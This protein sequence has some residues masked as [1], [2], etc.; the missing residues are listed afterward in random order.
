[1]TLPPALP[2][3]HT[4]RAGQRSSLQYTAAVAS[5]AGLVALANTGGSGFVT[6]P[7]TIRGAGHA[8]DTSAVASFMATSPTVGAKSSA[9]NSLSSEATMAARIAL[10][11]AAVV[12]GRAAKNQLTSDAGQASLRGGGVTPRGRSTSVS[13]QLGGVDFSGNATPWDTI[14]S[15]PLGVEDLQ[16]VHGVLL[17]CAFCLALFQAG[18]I[19][20]HQ[21]PSIPEVWTTTAIYLPWTYFCWRDT[22]KLEGH[23]QVTFYASCGWAIMSLAS[24]HSVAYQASAPDY[25]LAI[26]YFGNFINAIAGIYFYGYHWSRM[27]RH[28]TQNRFRPLWIPGLV[29]L[30]CLHSLTPADLFK[31]LDDPKWWSTICQIYPDEWWWVADV[32]C[33]ELFV[34]AAA[35][36]LILLH[37]QGVFTG[38]KNAF[39]V[40]FCTI[41]LPLVVMVA[42][43]SW[44]RA[45][46]WQHYLMQGPKYW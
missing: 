42:E 33:I 38:M 28:F 9:A 5:V 30:M 35:L 39:V 25:S 3:R 43:T 27:W 32:R 46:S 7:G 12:G 10:L 34:T 21:A 6:A 44:L 15:K 24:L 41:F 20:L 19:A 31:R 23:Y 17:L 11:A 1:M 37:I 45:S 14:E 16:N 2:R 36:W 29:G 18:R 22:A 8:T 4:C 26:L 40:V 13:R